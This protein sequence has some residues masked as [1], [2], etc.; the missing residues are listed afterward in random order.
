[1]TTS[2]SVVSGAISSMSELGKDGPWLK[3]W[4]KDQ[5]TRLG[6]GDLVAAHEEEV[7]DDGT[8]HSFL[9]ADDERCLSVDVHLGGFEAAHGF[10]LLDDWARNRVRLPD[11]KHVA[12]LVTESTGDR[13]RST[14]ETL[15]EHLPLVVVELQV[16]RGENEAIIV[17]HVALA[18][19]DVDL[20]STSAAAAARAIAKS[21][22]VAKPAAVDSRPVD[23][24]AETNFSGES[25]PVDDSAAPDFQP[26]DTSAESASPDAV[27][28]AQ[29]PENKDDTG[30]LDP[31]GTGASATQGQDDANRPRRLLTKVS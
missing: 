9:A 19:A 17:P 1:M 6:L 23:H 24:P 11:K 15:A 27:G 16:W 21:G 12:V 30:V 18:S 4:L 25:T 13:Y 2:P 31:W 29:S 28:T 3:A 5:P 22:Q 14:L 8:D 7:Q 20:S 10:G 26:A